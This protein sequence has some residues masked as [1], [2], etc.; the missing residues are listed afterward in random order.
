MSTA[1]V[2]K[3]GRVTIPASIR[4]HLRVG[5][6]DALDF[7]VND[8]GEMVVRPVTHRPGRKPASLEENDAA[9]KR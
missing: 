8:Q 9:T 4:E 5:P 1:T 3:N 6:G 7:I 2:K